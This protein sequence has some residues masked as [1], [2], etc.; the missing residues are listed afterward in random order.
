MLGTINILSV[1]LGCCI[2]TSPIAS[3]SSIVV[4]PMV[5]SS[6][7]LAV[8]VSYDTRVVSMGGLRDL[9]ACDT[10]SKTCSSKVAMVSPVG[11]VSV[12]SGS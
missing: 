9:V 11:V 2:V 7:G 5:D 12:V 1:T 8:A 6:T 3:L 4:S 10:T